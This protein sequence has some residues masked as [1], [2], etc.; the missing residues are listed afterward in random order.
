LGQKVRVLVDEHQKAGFKNIHW[1]GKDVQGVDVAS[2]VYFYGL[3]AGD[4]A[5]TKKMLLLK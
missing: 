1:D 4:F 5:E 3:E 2:G